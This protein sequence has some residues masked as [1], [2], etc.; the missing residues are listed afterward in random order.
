MLGQAPLEAMNPKP[1]ATSL[2]H[3]GDMPILLT[4]GRRFRALKC[5]S[6]FERTL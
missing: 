4:K 1:S 6:R 3:H 5:Q 2:N